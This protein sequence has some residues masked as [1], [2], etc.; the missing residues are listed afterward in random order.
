[1]ACAILLPKTFQ[2]VNHEYKGG[3]ANSNLLHISFGGYMLPD[4]EIHAGVQIFSGTAGSENHLLVAT[5]ESQLVGGSSARASWLGEVG[6]PPSNFSQM[7]NHSFGNYHIDVDADNDLPTYHVLASIWERGKV[8]MICKFRLYS[9][10]IKHRIL[11]VT[12]V[13]ASFFARRI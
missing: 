2:L 10:T 6:R 13:H 5:Q 12:F 3:T 1:M 9:E 7:R 11:S 4:L 8:L